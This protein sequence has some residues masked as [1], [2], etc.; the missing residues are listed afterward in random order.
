MNHFRILVSA[1]LILLATGAS[2]ADHYLCYEL[3][4]GRLL[5]PSGLQ[6][7]DALEFSVPTAPTEIAQGVAS[8]VQGDSSGA[9]AHWKPLADQGHPVAQFLNGA[10]H[11]SGNGTAQDFEAAVSLYKKAAETGYAVA[12]FGLA[13]AFETGR[14]VK[15][16]DRTAIKWYR[17]AA[18]QGLSAA[19]ERL[20]RL[21]NRQWLKY[22]GKTPD[23][24]VRVGIHLPGEA[25]AWKRAVRFLTSGRK[26]VERGRLKKAESDLKKA[27]RTF[28][29]MEGQSSLK[30]E[31]SSL[32]ASVHIARGRYRE[33]EGLLDEGLKG[34]SPWY[35]AGYAKED[36][37]TV[38]EINQ[39]Y[40][41]L[42]RDLVAGKPSQPA[43]KELAVPQEDTDQS[44]SESHR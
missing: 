15:T 44:Q 26:H 31:T 29:S 5:I 2:A 36:F 28:E 6:C 11:E 22:R 12:Q 18:S 16:D 30:A 10:L 27:L 43:T 9:L 17:A 33:A 4:K 25:N 14:G 41:L 8:L 34:I 39:N 42:Y 1:Y 23:R 32:L 24:S 35:G 20:A 38:A 21:H 40:Y 13:V 7:G 19:Y 3:S 37:A